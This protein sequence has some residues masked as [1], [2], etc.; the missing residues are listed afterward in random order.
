MT[1][2]E[3][4]MANKQPNMKVNVTADNSDLSRKMKESKSA[5]KD[6]EKVSGDALNSF[7]SALGINVDKVEKLSNAIKG[8]GIKMQSSGNAGV[9]SIG[10]LVTS[11]GGASTAIAG[12]GIGAAVASFKLLN[13]EATAFKN[14]VQG[15]SID[16]A[17]AAYVSTY[18]QTLHDANEA[19]GQGTAEQVAK[20][21]KAWNV[22]WADAKFVAVSTIADVLSGGGDPSAAL[23][24][25]LVKLAAIQS[26]ALDNADEAA[27]LEQRI[28]D[29]RLKIIEKT[30]GWARMEREIAEYKRVAY[31]KNVDTVTQQQALYKASELIEQRYKEEARLKKQMADLQEQYNSIASSSLDDVQKA[32]QLRIEEENVVARMNNALRELS[33]RQATVAANAAKEAQAREEALE[34]AQAMA[35]SREALKDWQQEAGLKKM[36][37]SEIEIPPVEVKVSEIEIPPVEVKVEKINLPIEDLEAAADR[38][39]EAFVTGTASMS[40]T[41][42]PADKMASIFDTVSDIVANM[43]EDMA[44]IVPLSSAI[45]SSAER[46]AAARAASAAAAQARAQQSASTETSASSLDTSSAVQSYTS[47]Y[48][49]LP[50]EAK[51]LAETGLAIPIKPELDTSSVVDISQQLESAI[52][53]ATEAVG[54][55]IGSLIG[56]LVSGGDAWSNFANTAL[57]AFGDLAI[58]VGRMAISTGVATLGIQAALQSLN[59]YVAIAAGVALVALGSAV[60]TGLAN[61]ASG[62]NY[63]SSANVATAGGYGSSSMIGSDFET[64]EMKVEVTGTL[65]ASGNELLTVI[66]NENTRKKHT[67]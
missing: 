51:A 17:T 39:E 47:I 50:K 21:S 32:N 34:Y 18:M 13:D 44:A 29:I 60:K 56:D 49:F 57:S 65:R 9:Q 67:T 55:S 48:D 59:G 8:L 27:R 63:S 54:E 14:T 58:S 31:D 15:A 11:I 25:S 12:L 6:F 1:E 42:G 52:T 4:N 33:E 2:S 16:M 22:F 64:R 36:K 43:R 5:V 45:A 35:A 20:I 19:I 10:K 7:G 23:N 30:V 38:L 62:G 3:N 37:V 61:I 26:Q 28:Y 66:E 53:S 41:V 46:E 24:R 40:E